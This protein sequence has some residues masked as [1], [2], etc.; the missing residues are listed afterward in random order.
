[1]KS[2]FGKEFLRTIRH[3]IGRFVAILLIVSL[4][5]GFYA[6][7]RATAPDMRQTMDQYMDEYRMMDLRVISTLGL[8]EADVDAVRDVDG[9][10]DVMPAHFL[11][12][13]TEM[14][15]SDQVVRVHSLPENTDADASGYLN[16]V[17]LVEGRMPE[18][19]NECLMM[20][21]KRKN[22][23]MF[24]G[25]RVVLQDVDSDQLKNTEYIVVGLIESAYY[26]SF[27]LGSSDIGDGTLNFYMYIPNSNFTTDYYEELF[28]S[29]E[30]ADGVNAFSDDYD[31][32]VQKVEKRLEKLSIGQLDIRRTELAGDA[33]AQLE[34]AKQDYET[35][36]AE[37]EQALSDAEQK[38]N[39]G[40][41]ELE[42]RR[43]Q[44]TDAMQQ[45][46]EGKEKLTE[47]EQQIAEGWAAYQ[48]GIKQLEQARTEYEAGVL[49]YNQGKMQAESKLQDAQ[50]QLLAGK[51]QLLLKQQL[52]KQVQKTETTAAQS[53]ESLQTQLSDLREQEAAETDPASKR[54]LQTTI[55]L[56]EQ[57]LQT[58]QDTLNSIQ[59]QERDLQTEISELNATV[60]SGDA[61]L[62]AQRAQ[63]ETQLML[64]EQKLN[65]AYSA[66]TAN[67]T[68][69]AE[70]KTQLETGEQELAEQSAKLTQTEAELEAAQNQLT[71]AE[72][73]LSNGRVELD[74]QR[75][76]AE[77][78][79]AEAEQK[80]TDGEARL[81]SLK[82]AVWYVLDRHA[83]VGFAS[84][85]GD[86]NRM[87]SL[88]KV[89]P[90]IFFAVAI[91]VALTTM[92]RMVEE[93][94][95][96]I[97]TY[98][99]LGYSR[100][101]IMSKYLLY[102]AIATVGGCILG[103]LVLQKV[104]PVIIW[105]CYRILY[106]GPS[107]AAPYRLKFA[108]IGTA[109]SIICVLGAAYF[110]CRSSVAECPARLLQPKVPKAGKR[111]LLERIP[112]IWKRLKFNQ[113]VTA[114]N[115]FRYKKRLIMTVAGIAGCTGL[116]LTGFGIKNS[117]SSLVPNQ[118]GE[119]YQYDIQMTTEEKTLSDETMLLFSRSPEIQSVLRLYQTAQDLTRNGHTMTANIVVPENTELFPEFIQL[120]SRVTHDPVEFQADSVIVTEKLASR[121][122]LSVGDTLTLQNSDGTPVEFTI[123]G[124]TENY[125]MHYI[126]IAPELYRQKLGEIEVFNHIDLICDPDMNVDYAELCAKLSSQPDIR[127]A[128]SMSASS[129]NFDS[130]I[131]S[132]NYIVLVIIICAGLL[133]F[134][135]LYNLTN[136]NISERQREIA[137][138]KVLGFHKMETAM[139]IYR[140]TI[141]LTLLGCIFGLGFG[142]ILHS[143]VIQT[144][145]VDMVMFGRTIEPLSFLISAALTFAFSFLVNVVMYRK[146]TGI[147]MVESLKSVD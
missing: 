22:S 97:G 81:E 10:A 136:I 88:S 103:I 80:I 19:E 62:T 61:E 46:A 83:N 14:N 30:N 54:L 55:A 4:G 23:E 58:A 87:N 89:F 69:L 130:M 32:I 78:Q 75:A 124:I 73:E 76:E 68:K 60:S 120:R 47:T 35:G 15:G 37:T 143:F 28:I 25:E 26:I 137:T 57:E 141:L 1:M 27:Q 63:I 43:Q 66:I 39:D 122:D 64:A 5:A 11:D 20:A 116:L 145:E 74:T 6:S 31:Q 111:I 105:N 113:K 100:K 131:S 29:V 44:W 129:K 117:V 119:L 93:E 94:R 90:V 24:L 67:E 36:K 109:V 85:E 140:E 86:C 13:I 121:L 59:Q 84:F 40:A 98:S 128:T 106:T 146:L 82:H 96:L 126:Y 92:T 2:A 18:A 134:I 45:V 48:S 3:S 33:E 41:A 142:V 42:Q 133:A 38:L 79:L 112:F 49:E 132:L 70:T 108:L 52:L 65:A 95:S 91:L 102:A 104:L 147:S 118:Y 71:E 101:R 99:A 107:I 135:V 34:Q 53:V 127:T 8:T 139:Y 16:Q 56:R 51:A 9:V 17:K 12:A 123:T 125:I 138:I 110:V 77:A 115:I 144:V 50:A 114:R 72:T 21:G 7:L